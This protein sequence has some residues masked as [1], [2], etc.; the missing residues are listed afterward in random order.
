MKKERLLEL[1][2]KMTLSWLPEHRAL[3][4]EWTN[5]FVTLDEFKQLGAAALPHAEPRGGRAWIIDGSRARNVFPPEVQTF[6]A[7]HAFAGLVAHHIAYF[8]SIPSQVSTTTNLGIQRYE[9]HAG[10]SGI[11]L[12]TAASLDDALRFLREVDGL[13]AAS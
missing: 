11:Q 8:I 9:R 3:L 7:E 13:R 1:P 5:Y 6:I 10:P 2:G 12:V 4:D